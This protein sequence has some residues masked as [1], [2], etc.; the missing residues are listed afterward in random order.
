MNL[1]IHVGDRVFI[2]KTTRFDESI[3]AHNVGGY[4]SRLEYN[5]V[6]L[7]IAGDL[8]KLDCGTAWVK[9]VVS[10]DRK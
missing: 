3:Y 7:E 6:V 9:H 10:I 4:P 5:G 8:L 2:Q 1:D